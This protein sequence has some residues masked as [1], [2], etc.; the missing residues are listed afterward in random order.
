MKSSQVLYILNILSLILILFSSIRTIT[1][2]S[3]HQQLIPDLDLTRCPPLTSNPK[4]LWAYWHRGIYDMPIFVQQNIK[5]WQ[6]LNPDWEI[7]LVQGADYSSECHY[8]KLIPVELLPVYISTLQVQKISDAVR[9]ALI[10]LHGGVYMDVTN[11]LFEPLDV[12]HWN[13]VSLPKDD[14]NRKAL[15]GYYFDIYCLP[16]RHDGFEIWMMVAQANEPLIIA[17]HD[18]FLKLMNERPLP[19]I[20]NETTGEQNAMFKDVNFTVLSELI[21][22][23]GVST[24]CLHA[25]LQLNDTMNDIYENKSLIRDATLKTYRLNLEFSFLPDKLYNFFVNPS[26]LTRPNLERM[27][28][29]IPLMKVI[30]HAWYMT[31]AKYD[32]WSRIDNI[33]TFARIHIFEK[34][35]K[36]RQTGVWDPSVF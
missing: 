2:L 35:K 17:W 18:L 11:I 13:H 34:G 10:R 8:T 16:G 36:W 1:R 22:N 15:V 33:M 21:L 26:M 7:R 4:R 28:K 19:F 25:L 31:D 6:L 32:E 5:M 9:L 20:R 14:P 30:N 23:Y 29:G 24:T 12:D 3:W 27:V